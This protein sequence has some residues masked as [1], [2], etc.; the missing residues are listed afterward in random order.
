MSKN[1]LT[2]H[3]KRIG[4]LGGKAGRGG[5]KQ[6]GDGEYYRNLQRRAVTSRRKRKDKNNHDNE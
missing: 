6:R 5:A 2:E 3:L 1:E 4:A